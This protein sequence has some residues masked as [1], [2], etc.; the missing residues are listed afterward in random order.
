M[1]ERAEAVG[2]GDENARDEEVEDPDQVFSDAQENPVPIDPKEM[3][4]SG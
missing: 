2:G 4:S 1:A 3:A